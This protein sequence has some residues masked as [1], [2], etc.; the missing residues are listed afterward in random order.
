MNIRTCPEQPVV[1][2]PV[3][4]IVE[5]VEPGRRKGFTLIEM[6]VVI[7]IIP[8]AAF[9]LDRFFYAFL[10]DIP[11]SSRV[12]QE[13]TT[14]LNMISQM[15]KDI[16]KATGLPEAFA[17][18]SSGDKL[19]L[20]EQPDGII[21]YQLTND[22]VLRYV[23]KDARN[24]DG[25]ETRVWSVPNAVVQL[26]VLRSNN[27]GYAVQVCTYVKQKLREKQQKKMANSHLF[28]VG[29]L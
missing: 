23:L 8:F 29:A 19:L 11:R 25:K 5:R 12:V 13:N 24:E 2:K 1:S 10:M 26:S 17:G 4:S 27:K 28:F 15:S 3:L 6:L 16:D 7:V 20:I 14:V 9:A 18:Q 21:C 22:Q